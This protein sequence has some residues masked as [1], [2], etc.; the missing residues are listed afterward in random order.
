MLSGAHA[1]GGAGASAG[2][3]E[4]GGALVGGAEVSATDGS[5]A[6]AEVPAGSPEPSLADASAEPVAPAAPEL[7]AAEVVASEG[8]SLE[9]AAAGAD[10]GSAV[11][12][13]ETTHRISATAA[14]NATIVTARRRQ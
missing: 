14:T 8:T 5:A 3:C 11:A 2:V 1:P 12:I 10:P 7:S 13:R 9:L 6:G 4:A